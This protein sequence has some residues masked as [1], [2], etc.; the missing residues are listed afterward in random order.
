MYTRRTQENS[1]PKSRPTTQ[2]KQLHI[3]R[4]AGINQVQL[5]FFVWMLVCFILV[6]NKSTEGRHRQ[7]GHIFP[8]DI[9]VKLRLT[10]TA[11]AKHINW[12]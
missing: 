3:D 2:E 5:S 12:L 8:G 6:S 9:M 4:R 1:K 7:L 10:V 11:D